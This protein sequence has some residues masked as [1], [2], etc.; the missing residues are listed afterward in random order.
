[1][2]AASAPVRLRYGLLIFN[3]FTPLDLALLLSPFVVVGLALAA[4]G[5]VHLG[6]RL[7]AVVLSLPLVLGLLSALWTRDPAATFYYC[8]QSALALAAYLLTVNLL[9]GQPPTLVVRLTTGFVFLAVLVPVLSFAR[10]PGF[11]PTILALEGTQDATVYSLSYYTR[12]SHPFW[13]L[14]N[15]LATILAF[16]PLLLWTAARERHSRIIGLVAVLAVVGVLATL[17]RGIAVA[18][19]AGTG[20]FALLAGSYRRSVFVAL[21]V[22]VAALVGAALAIEQLVGDV[23]G[24]LSDR[25]T[26]ASV[27]VRAA[28]FEVAWEKLAAAPLLGYGAGVVADSHPELQGGTHNTY[29]ES[30]LYYGVPL[31]ML[32][33]LSLLSLP[34]HLAIRR[35][36]AAA[37]SAMPAALASSVA[38]LLL[39][40]AS[41]SSFEGALLR[42]V[43]YFSLAL[44]VSLLDAARPGGGAARA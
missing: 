18:L 3:S 16:F 14:S 26:A 1:M 34:L 35:R 41:Q 15:N 27:D 25:F 22:L 17:S 43:I 10:V 29:I 33:N 24:L 42:V 38:V 9:R 11:E 4:N 8:V 7:V 13:G 32:F 2:L 30:L 23:P 21:A 20:L 39:V 28:K 12:L 6:D 40:F 31:G 37:P 44:G 19:V 5:R 36:R